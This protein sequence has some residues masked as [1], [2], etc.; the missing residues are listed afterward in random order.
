M[1]EANYEKLKQWI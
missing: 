1:T